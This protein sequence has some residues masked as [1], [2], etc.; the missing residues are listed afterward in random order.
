[1][2]ETVSVV[3]EFVPSETE[4]VS[5]YD[6]RVSKSRVAAV[7]IAPDAALIAKAVPVFPAVIA[8]SLLS[9]SPETVT[10]IT[11][12]LTEDVSAILADCPAVISMFTSETATV[13]CVEA[14]LES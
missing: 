10:V 4:I 8:K 6:A 5:V 3:A 1:M 9:E 12:E 7:V 14:V 11:A 2:I 13:N